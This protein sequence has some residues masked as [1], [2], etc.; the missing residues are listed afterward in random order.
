MGGAAVPF[1]AWPPRC[2]PG[3][4]WPGLSHGH[5]IYRGVGGLE[6]VDFD[7]PVGLAQCGATGVCLSGLGHV[8]STRYTYAVRPVAG[9]AWLETPD[10]S[11]VVEMET[12]AAGDWIGNRPAKV[13]WVDAEVL[14]G[15]RVKLKWSYRTPCGG[16]APADFGL[17]WATAPGIVVGSPQATTTYAAD[18]AYS[19]TFALSDGEAYWFAVTA[20]TAGGLESPLSAETGPCVADA[21]PPT[22]PEVTVT[23]LA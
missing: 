18:G 13:E 6:N 14:S 1:G 10:V 16:D 9:T 4:H 15:G 12:D 19:H 2:L 17:Y 11:C 20:R 3:C 22:A 8:A 21:T 5:R 7:A 23:R